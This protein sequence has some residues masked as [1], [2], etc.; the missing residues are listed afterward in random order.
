MT[1]LNKKETAERAKT[2]DPSVHKNTTIKNA[3]PLKQKVAA[4]L[5]SSMERLYPGR[6][7]KYDEYDDN[8]KLKYNNEADRIISMIRRELRSKI[9]D[10][11]LE[12]Q[13]ETVE[14]RIIAAYQRGYG[15]GERTEQ[16]KGGLNV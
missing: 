1:R 14:A 11:V 10:E 2:R 12:E 4:Q 9:V 15:N 16:E 7:G 3:K 5:H 6:F 13:R 8:M